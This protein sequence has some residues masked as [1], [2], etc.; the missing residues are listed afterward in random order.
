MQAY[1]DCIADSSKPI[2][3]VI[4]GIKATEIAYGCNK[5]Y[6]EDILVRL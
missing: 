4:D 3:G 5:S 2:V 6:K 1:V